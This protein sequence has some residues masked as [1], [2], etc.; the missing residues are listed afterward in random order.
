[1]FL[2]PGTPPTLAPPK[3]DDDWA[4]FTLRAGFKLAEILYTTAPL[5][6]N[7]IDTLLNLWNTT[8]VPHNNTAPFTD[9][10]DVHSTI[11]AIKLDNVPWQ[12]YTAQYNGLYPEDGP[13]PEWMNTDYQLWYRDPRKVIHSILANPNLV[14]GIDYVP[15]R[16]FKN[17]NR[18]YCDF[19][20]ANW[21]WEQ[22]VCIFLSFYLK[23]LPH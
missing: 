7:A 17:D 20:S 8:L 12:S 16:E 14:D 19:M 1:M 21:A 9:H 5:S 13:T 3:P 11:D 10:K 6:N 15:Y 23:R 18:R 22:C 4:P 2:P